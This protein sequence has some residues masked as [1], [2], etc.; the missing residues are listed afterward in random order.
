MPLYLYD[1]RRSGWKKSVISVNRF[2]YCNNTQKRKV[3]THN[4]LKKK[5]NNNNCTQHHVSTCADIK[6]T[7]GLAEELG[8]L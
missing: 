8:D 6:Y 4:P 1:A 3:S 2:D 7:K 5:N